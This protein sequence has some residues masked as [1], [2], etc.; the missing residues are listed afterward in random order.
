MTATH[1]MNTIRLVL[2]AICLTFALVTSASAQANL[3]SDPSFETLGANATIIATFP[4][5]RP[6]FTCGTIGTWRIDSATV[7]A[8]VN[9]ITPSNGVHM[10]ES[11]SEVSTDMYQLVD[12]SSLARQIDAGRVSLN[13]SGYF[14]S[15]TAGKSIAVT[16]LAFATC[17]ANFEDNLG[18]STSTSQ[19]TDSN[20]AT[21]QQASTGQSPTWI[22]PR[23][24][25]YIAAGLQMGAVSAHTYA[26]NF[27]LTTQIAAA[28][29]V[30]LKSSANNKYVT[31]ESAGASSLI[32]RATAIGEWETYDIVTNA[33]GTVSLFAW[34]NNK[35]VTAEDAGASALIARA[36][37]I[38]TWEKYTKVLNSNGTISFLAAAN[39]K[40][41][42]A[43]DGG[44]SPLI[45]R[46]TAIG[47][48]EMYTYQLLP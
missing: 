13:Y 5:T 26:D 3:L 20:L 11:L 44:D 9:G 30:A 41:V 32:A 16:L 10:L 47:S 38:G 29:H 21:W 19:T 17:A 39:S 23:G 34:A 40:Y 36:T 2:A 7:R 24:T 42:T 35:F 25:R 45:A 14:N 48:W 18:T 27:S 28:D 12:L 43:E 31:A 46:A 1:T 15:D 8:S 37:A 6:D 4:T 22:V 33:D